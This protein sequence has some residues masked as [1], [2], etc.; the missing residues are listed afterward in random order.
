MA[1]AVFAHQVNQRLLNDRFHIDSAGTAGY[2]AGDKPDSRSAATCKAHGVP[3]NHRARQVQKEDFS[4]FDHILC[5]DNSNLRDL[6]RMQPRGS[7]AQVSLFGAYDEQSPGSIIEDPYYGGN[8]GF[9]VNYQQVMPVS[10]PLP[11]SLPSSLLQLATPSSTD[12]MVLPESRRI[13]RDYPPPSRPPAIM[14][15]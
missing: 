2:H 13:R 7:K 6:K 14:E 12:A 3:V 9:E 15:Y 5:M 8:E 10:L 4:Q 1:E 11:P